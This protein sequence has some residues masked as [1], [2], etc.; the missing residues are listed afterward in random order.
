ML[1]LS[2]FWNKFVKYVEWTAPCQSVCGLQGE[3]TQAV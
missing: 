1:E 3:H 2:Q